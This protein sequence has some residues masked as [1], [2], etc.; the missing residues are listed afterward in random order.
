MKKDIQITT[1]VL[2]V[3]RDEMKIRTV[4]IVIRQNG[5]R[6]SHTEV[7]RVPHFGNWQL[8]SKAVHDRLTRSVKQWVETGVADEVLAE[9]ELEYCAQ[10]NCR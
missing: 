3:C 7:K 4:L 1:E 10:A 2:D 5:L 8:E 9:Y 6:S